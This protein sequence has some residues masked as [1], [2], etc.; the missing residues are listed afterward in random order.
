MAHALCVR[1]GP[2]FLQIQP[3]TRLGCFRLQWDKLHA[4]PNG[5]VV[6]D[7]FA[8][9]HLGLIGPFSRIAASDCVSARKKKPTLQEMD[10]LFSPG[11]DFSQLTNLR[12][13]G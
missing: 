1:D 13:S 10:F 8:D 7:D 2:R 3:P 4:R 5:S 9:H 11:A 6:A 12:A